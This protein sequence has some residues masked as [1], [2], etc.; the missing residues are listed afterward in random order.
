MTLSP[1]PIIFS[2]WWPAFQLPSLGTPTVQE[3]GEGSWLEG[4]LVQTLC[5]ALEAVI[6]LQ[7]LLIGGWPPLPS[8]N[9]HGLLGLWHLLS[10]C[11]SLCI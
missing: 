10:R 5:Q 9:L 3:A 8:W 7:F 1:R 11:R 6:Y 2:R 4:R